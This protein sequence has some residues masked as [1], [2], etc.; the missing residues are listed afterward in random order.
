MSGRTGT[1][2]LSFGS[3]QPTV[4]DLSYSRC[5]MRPL[6][7]Q[8]WGNPSHSFITA[9]FASCCLAYDVHVV[10]A[11]H[12][13]YTHLLMRRVRIRRLRKRLV[14]IETQSRQSAP[15]YGIPTPTATAFNFRAVCSV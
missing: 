7:C 4:V 13:R 8:L 9:D 14:A 6:I 2:C 10:I 11:G 5:E 12:I 3:R 15:M 1:R